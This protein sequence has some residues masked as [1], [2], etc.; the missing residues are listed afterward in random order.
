MPEKKTIRFSLPLPPSKNK[1]NSW[2][3]GRIMSAMR[4]VNNYRQAVA[5]MLRKFKGQLPEG[6]KIVVECVWFKHSATQ[7][8]ANFHDELLDA[9][10]PPLGLNDRFALVRDMD[11]V[12]EPENPRVEVTMWAIEGVI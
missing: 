1:R 11:Y 8:A 9:V 5:L 3:K 12:I 2:G 10:F 4:V 6:F 7:D